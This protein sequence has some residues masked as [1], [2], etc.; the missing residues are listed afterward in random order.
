MRHLTL[1]LGIVCSIAGA[2]AQDY[3][4]KPVKIVVPYAAGGSTDILTRQIS[5]RVTARLGQSVVVENR[6]GANGII[7]TDVVA[8]SAPDGYTLLMMTNGQTI[9]MGLYPKLPW[10]IEKDFAPVV[11]VA[12]M[13][14]VIVVHP[15]QPF[16]SLKELLDHV[17]AKP[18]SLSYS[19]AGVG[20]PQHIAGEL[21][22]LVTK[23]NIVQIPYKGGGPAIA[24]AVAGQV[25]VAVGGVPVVKQHIANGR[26]RPLAVTSSARSPLLADVPTVAEFGYAGFDAIFWIGLLAPRGTPDA[27][28]ARINAEVNAVLKDPDIV[29]QFAVQGATPVGGTP[30]DFGAYIRKDVETSGRVIRDA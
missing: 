9:S 22:K 4:N 27:A 16:N 10:D 8:K 5:V 24:D 2:Q 29:T 26:L 7:G 6:T 25:Q 30:A 28:I 19:H 11:N 14:N 1:L 23:A 15:S 17:R 18:G 21:F 3:P 20:S 13:P 12:A